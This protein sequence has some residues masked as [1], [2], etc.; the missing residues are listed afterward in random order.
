M[1]YSEAFDTY[2]E[3]APAHS[4]LGIASF[5]IAM[6][7]GLLEFVLVIIAGILESTTPGGIDEN[8]PPGILLGLGLIGG[9]MLDLLGIGIGIGGLCDRKRNRLFAA[10]GVAIGSVVLFGVLFLAAIG[11][12]ME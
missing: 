5:V 3:P 2:D 12:T 9:L 4:G 7:T 6:G 8:S 11:L 1:S 10:L